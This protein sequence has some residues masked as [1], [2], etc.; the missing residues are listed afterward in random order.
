MKRFMNKKVAAI[1]LAAGLVLG[2]AGAAFAYFTSTGSGTGSATVGSSANWTVG[3]TG[4]PSGGPLYPDPAIGGA[5]VQTDTYTVT[6]NDTGSQYL[7]SVQV[8]VANADGTA[9]SSQTNPLLPACTAADFS[10]GSAAVGTTWTDTSL[11]GT[12]TASGTPGDTASSTVTVELIDN[13]A[14]QDNCEGLTVPLYFYAS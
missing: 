5:N 9:W 8:S 14:N 12:Y 10:V 7:T 11:A 6:N 4:S 1:G 13:H 3:E 2:A